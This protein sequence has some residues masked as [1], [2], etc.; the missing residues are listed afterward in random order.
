MGGGIYTEGVVTLRD[1]VVSSNTAK[2]AGFGGGLYLTGTGSQ[3]TVL[4]STF[5]SNEATAGGG[6]SGDQGGRLD[7]GRV[8]PGRNIATGI[9]GGGIYVTNDASASLYNTNVDNN[10]ANGNTGGGIR[11]LEADVTLRNTTV[12]GNA[13]PDGGGISSTDKLP[14]RSRVHAREHDRRRQ[15][16][17]RHLG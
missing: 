16:R 6:I 7:H 2:P 1:T 4:T 13:A 5:R 8:S 14:E 9:S 15:S 12:T 10:Q 17:H 11:A 3:V